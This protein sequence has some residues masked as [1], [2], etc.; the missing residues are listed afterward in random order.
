MKKRTKLGIKIFAV[1]LICIISIGGF[2]GNYFYNL[3]LNPNTPKDMIFA[4]EDDSS[5]LEEGE[6]KLKLAKHL[7]AHQINRTDDQHN[8]EHPDPMRNRGEPDAHIDTEC[9]NIGNRNNQN[10]KAVGP[11]GD[12]TRHWAQIIL[13]IARKRAGLRIINRHL[14][15]RTHDDKG[16]N[17]ADQISQ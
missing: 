5:D 10:F 7:H 11:S 15:K 1:M 2:V 17:A 16:D 3:A 12:I 6:P 8:A 13:R 14:T 4:S 9:G